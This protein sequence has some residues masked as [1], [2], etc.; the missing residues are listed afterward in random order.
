MEVPTIISYSSLQQRIAEQLIDIP[1]PHDRG[2]RG[3]GGGLQGFSR[4]QGSSAFRGAEFVDI[5]VPPGRGGLGG[6][7]LHSFSQR[8]G[9]TAFYGADHTGFPV[10]SGRVGGGG[11]QGFLPGQGSAASSS[12]VGSAEEAGYGVFRTF[13]R[14][15][16][17]AGYGPH[18]GSELGADF[19][20]WTPAAYAESMEG[21]FDVAVEESEAAVVVEEGAETRFAAGFQPMRVCTRFLE[22]QLGR[23]VRGCAYG[24][25][26]TFAHSWAELHPEASAHEQQLASHF[27]D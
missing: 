20:P 21:A 10:P 27:P 4:G 5:P 1:V 23:P 22:H 18:S 12:H 6:G 13:P 17:S 19:T 9:S 2:G 25:R 8:Q 15:K 24:D 14:L 26:C 3:G 16:K 7:G 11:L